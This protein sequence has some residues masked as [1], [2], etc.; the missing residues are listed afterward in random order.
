M[1]SLS[2]S[3]CCSFVLVSFLTN[4]KALTIFNLMGPL[5]LSSIDQRLHVELQNHTMIKVRKDL[6]RSSCPNPP[7]QVGTPR[8]G[9]PGSPW[10][11]IPHPKESKSMKVKGIRIR[12][13]IIC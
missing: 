7:A 1:D 10:F 5:P 3:V 6:S 8:T 13:L 4:I 9:Y 12:S 11:E 2:F